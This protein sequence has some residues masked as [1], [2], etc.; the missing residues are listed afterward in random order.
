MNYGDMTSHELISDHE[1]IERILQGDKTLYAILVHR[2]NQSLYRIG[3]SILNDEA[4]V[5]D[6][7]QAA[8][9]HAYENLHQFEFKSEFHTWMTKI[10]IHECQHRYNS[11]KR[12]VGLNDEKYEDM[13]LQKERNES[14]AVKFMNGELKTILN[15]VI[16]NLPEIYRTVFVL[17][18]IEHLSIEET[19]HC[20]NI[21]EANVKV[22][23]N[24]AKAMLRNLLS[25]YY[26]EEELPHIHLNRGNRLVDAVLQH[27][28]SSVSDD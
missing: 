4:E 28:R 8:Y 27:Q 13:M 9:I 24:R 5:E 17:R 16:Y 26:K 14:P 20:L 3:M 11:R 18:E 1:L 10:L 25:S 6:A 2:Y 12:S 19:R 21:S 7:M 22:R 15:Q 23:L